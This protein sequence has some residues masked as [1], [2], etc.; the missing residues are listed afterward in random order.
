MLNKEEEDDVFAELKR[1]LN[2]ESEN[3]ERNEDSDNKEISDDAA[4]DEEAIKNSREDKENFRT[5][6][7]E[8]YEDGYK[9]REALAEKPQNPKNTKIVKVSE[10]TFKSKL[11][12]VFKPDGHLNKPLIG[13]AAILMM[14]L[15]F[16]FMMPGNADENKV[17]GNNMKAQTVPENSSDELT[18]V[19][20]GTVDKTIGNSNSGDSI[21]GG[22]DSNS[23][24]NSNS[25]VPGQNANS[26]M[27]A[28][29]TPP[30]GSTTTT[31]TYT[32]VEP[33]AGNKSAESGQ[34]TSKP[35]T[36]AIT[37][38]RV[39]KKSVSENFTFEFEDNAPRPN[40]EQTTNQGSQNSEADLPV[41]NL[42]IMPGTKI[43]MLLREPFRSGIETKVQAVC[44]NNVKGVDGKILISANSI[45]ELIF[46]PEEVNGRILAKEIA[47][48]Y[49][50]D[51]SIG[52]VVGMVKGQDGYAGLGGKVSGGKSVGSRII[53]GLSRI[54]GRIIG[55]AG[56][57]GE[58]VNNEIQNNNNNNANIYR[59]SR[60]VEVKE[61]T[62]F[63]LIVGTPE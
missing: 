26:N 1:T 60:I 20:P 11:L 32:T 7:A 5:D 55:E 45:F 30:G 16:V 52:E 53:G 36:A 33:Q 13:G 10:E 24:Y 14:F 3:T 29:V 38:N 41:K 28:S 62:R 17:V 59:S 15:L 2:P 12:S 6:D 44:L 39:N 23:A 19:T 43:Q 47:R 22:G 4:A 27:N 56:V 50:A 58:D 37:Q 25:A 57:V 8:N 48:V 46:R 34:Q 42:K 51:N 31:Q 35:E 54:G 49:L 40:N 61:G 9:M 63:S 21:L 18:G